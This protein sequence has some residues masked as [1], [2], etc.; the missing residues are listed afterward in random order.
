[1]AYSS[2]VLCKAH[3]TFPKNQ[4]IQLFLYVACIRII[5]ATY[6]G[7]I[8]G[9]SSKLNILLSKYA[10]LAQCSI[11]Y[12]YSEVGKLLDEKYIPSTIQRVGEPLYLYDSNGVGYEIAVGT[13]GTLTATA[14]TE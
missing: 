8:Q 4:Y 13:D 11:S 3:T 12:T 9:E 10:S 14:V 2:S 6:N 5:E 7:A 1:M